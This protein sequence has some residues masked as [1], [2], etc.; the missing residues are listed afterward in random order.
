MELYEGMSYSYNTREQKRTDMS[1]RT[2]AHLEA[3][4]DLLEVMSLASTGALVADCIWVVRDMYIG[5]VTPGMVCIAFVLMVSCTFM[6]RAA[7]QYHKRSVKTIIKQRLEQRL[8]NCKLKH[9]RC[10]ARNGKINK[11]F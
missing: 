10:T 4:C 3:A 1:I 5:G 8:K 11:T 7:Y 6:I 2:S 9:K